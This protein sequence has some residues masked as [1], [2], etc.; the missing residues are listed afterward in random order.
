MGADS[1][2]HRWR[3]GL[4]YLVED[5]MARGRTVRTVDS[6]ALMSAWRRAGGNDTTDLPRDAELQLARTLGA[7]RLLIP[8]LI[9][10]GG[11]QTVRAT[12]LDVASRR[13]PRS[14]TAKGPSDS[15]PALIDHVVAQLLALDANEE[16]AV[17]SALASASLPALDA[18]LEGRMLYRAGR[19]VEARSAFSEALSH[20]STFALAGFYLAQTGWWPAEDG[21]AQSR[22]YNVAWAGREKLPLPHRLRLMLELGRN[23]GRVRGSDGE[24]LIDSLVRAA[25]HSAETWASVADWLYHWGRSVGMVDADTRAR[26]AFDRSLELDSSFAPVLEHLPLFYWQVGDTAATRRA[27]ELNAILDTTVQGR[28]ASDLEFAAF[29]ADSADGAQVFNRLVS[30]RD[31]PTL[32]RLITLSTHT[33]RYL[34]IADAAARRMMELSVTGSERAGAAFNAARYESIVG[35]PVAAAGLR[36]QREGFNRSR[37]MIVDRLLRDGD[38]VAAVEG[39][40]ELSNIV[41]D[42]VASGGVRSLQWTWYALVLGQ[43]C[44]AVGDL[45]GARRTVHALREATF[46]PDKAWIGDERDRYVLLI[47]AQLASAE[48]R[49]EARELTEQL[50]T[51]LRS[52]PFAANVSMNQAEFY[53]STGNL[54]I[55]ALWEKLGNIDR[56]LAALRREPRVGSQ[57]RPGAF[58]YEYARL[59]ALTGNRDQA[60]KAY[61]NYLL[62][63]A[64]PEPTLRPKVDHVRAE[65]ARL[66]R[67]GG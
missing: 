55:A 18:Y 56:A 64:N 48:E 51:T 1:S 32:N 44:I 47:A 41:E 53:L 49:P 34:D 16:A 24:Q 67:E 8:S 5:K 40:R 58:L 66:E 43:G 15:I 31:L 30:N 46:A 42:S 17:A 33:G 3:E 45:K 7:G 10:D 63:R 28:D 19:M 21:A 54:A 27:V 4:V 12:M 13:L 36:R 23:R 52:A 38:S 61:R 65:L 25:P 35:H 50:D 20:D 22:G 9:S 26:E 29:V 60:I 39:V 62:V 2:L 59:S 37:D 14:A 57:G 11:E 6:H